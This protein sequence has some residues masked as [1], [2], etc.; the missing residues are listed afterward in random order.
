MKKHQATG[1]HSVPRRASHRSVVRKLVSLIPMKK[2]LVTLFSWMFFVALGAANAADQPAVPDVMV[3]GKWEIEM[4]M[5]GNASTSTLTLKQDGQ[6]LTGSLSG[7][8]G[9]EQPVTGKVDGEKITFSYVGDWQ[10]SELNVTYVGK[11][12]STGAITGMCEVQPF[13]I[14]GEFSAK[15]AKD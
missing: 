3:A 2:T 9:Q 5:V 4:E 13:G 14:S 6:K 15:R 1:W 7:P 11:L 8:E 12:N 10:G